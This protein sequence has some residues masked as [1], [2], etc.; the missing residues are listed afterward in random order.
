MA[1]I[2]YISLFILII[3]GIRIGLY[4][5]FEKAGEDGW[6]AFIPVYSDLIWLKLIGKPQWWVILTLIP[7]VRTLIKISMDIDLVKAYGKHKFGEQAKAVLIPFIYYPQIGFDKET[8]YVGV[9]LTYEEAVQKY[10]KEQGK[11]EKGKALGEADK[12]MSK[13]AKDR[14][15]DRNLKEVSKVYPN[16]I[17]PKSGSREWADA[18]LFAGVAALIIRT[19]FIEAFMIPTSSMER[20][21]MAGDFLFVSK[22][23]YGSR[24]PMTPLAVPFIHNKISVGKVKMPS[25]LDIVRLP[26]FRFPGVSDVE[27]ND[28]VVFNYPAH[29]IHDLG[30][31][32]GTQKIISTKENYIKRC[33]GMPGD[34]FQIDDGQVYVDGKKAWNPPNMQ[35]D[36]VVN[37]DGGFRFKYSDLE[38]MEFRAV[39]DRNGFGNPIRREKNGNWYNAHSG[40]DNTSFVMACTQGIVDRLQSMPEIKTVTPQ[41]AEKGVL[42]QNERMIPGLIAIYPNEPMN[43]KRKLFNHNRDNFGPIVIPKKGVTT[44]ITDPKNYR[45]YKRVIEAYE[46][47]SLKIQNGKP[48]IDGKESPTYTFEKNYYLMMG[49]NR[50]NSQ[51]SR[52]WGFVPDDHVV[53]TPLFVFFSYEASFGIRWDRIGTKNIN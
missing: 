17:A 32:A 19:F 51:D 10:N 46:G 30:D 3:I 16:V 36:Y 12:K 20:T 34:T 29:D 21:L 26:Y 23:E 35:F 44:N 50:H 7:I 28:I 24:M 40:A 25:Y 1:A 31:G 6:K 13:T 38:E 33:I 18:F 53:G 41:F 27:R 22:Y 9:P 43:A 4:K 45:L 2:F 39:E 52:Y 11:E 37:A 49:D 5:L 42:S 14:L 47:H 48:F 15:R 8:S